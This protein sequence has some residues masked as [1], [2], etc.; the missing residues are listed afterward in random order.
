MSQVL[1][2]EEFLALEADTLASLLDSDR[3]TVSAPSTE[4]FIEVQR[5]IKL[6]PFLQVPNEEVILD[7]V[8]RWMQH[9]PEVPSTFSL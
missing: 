6:N 2:T 5:E 4:S 7:A 8:I 3:L 1:E 9:D